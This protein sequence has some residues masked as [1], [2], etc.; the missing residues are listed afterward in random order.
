[1]SGEL[2]PLDDLLVQWGNTPLEPFQPCAHYYDAMDSVLYLQEDVS[3]R[4]DRVDTFLTLL[5]H[6]QDDRV[7]G[8]KL[9]GWRYLFQRLQSILQASGVEIPDS[10]FVRLISAIEVAITAAGPEI[11][12]DTERQRIDE[13]YAR[14]RE[15][16][17]D[18]R[19]D[20]SDIREAA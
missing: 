6:P 7:V 5:W 17:A 13:K 19:L 2:M 9:K 11:V 16:V 20:V 1:M 15:I 18:V 10:H 4:A 14:A 8:V 12:A 3:Y